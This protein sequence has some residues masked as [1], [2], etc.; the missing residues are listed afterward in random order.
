MK[1]IVL[2]L[3]MLVILSGCSELSVN[4]SLYVTSTTLLVADWGQTR[5]A[6]T[7]PQKFTENNVIMGKQPSIATVN[8]YFAGWILGNTA[9]LFIMP[10]SWQKY[11]FLC[12][13]GLEISAVSNNYGAGVHFS[14]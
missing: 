8:E 12:I 7:H 1:K 3:I 6:A 13:T 9:M 2:F 4:R 14:Y 11:W 5:Y 10:T